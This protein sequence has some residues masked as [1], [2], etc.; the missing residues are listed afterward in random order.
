MAITRTEVTRESDRRMRRFWLQNG[1]DVRRIREDAGIS[2]GQLAGVTGIHKSH[3]ARIEAGVAR[4]TIDVLST[5]GVALGADLSLRFFP[6]TGP[7]LHDRFQAPM[8]EALLRELDVRW[9]VEL[10]V[11]VVRP[12]RGVIDLVLTDKANATVVA[13]EVQSELRRLEQQ[14]RWSTEKAGGLASQLAGNGETSVVGN[15]SR[16]LVLRSTAATREIA[17]RYAMTLATAFPARS[18]DVF[19]ALTT[20]SAPWPGA[21][22]VWMNLH[23]RV[24]TLM[25]FPPRGVAVGR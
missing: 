17:R 21:G 25:A 9:L 15:V 4:P 3:V 6:G 22:I 13:G 24:A 19:L 8:I 2:I 10:E 18:H 20:S 7:R 5:I 11:P 23:G 12:S 1:E 16:L 14:I